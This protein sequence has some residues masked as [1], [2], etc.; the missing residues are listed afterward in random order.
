MNNFGFGGS[1]AHIIMDNASGYVSSRRLSE[2]YKKPTERSDSTHSMTN[3]FADPEGKDESCV[4]LLSSF[5]E[6]SGKQQAKNLA[7]YLLKHRDGY[8]DDLIRDLA[9]TLS[10]RRSN[11]PWKA[12]F[13]AHSLPQL[14]K[15]LSSEEVKFSRIHQPKNIGFVFTGQGAQWHAM[16]RELITQY[17]VF[18]RSLDLADQ[19]IAAMGASW[20]LYGKFILITLVKDL[21]RHH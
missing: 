2:K 10:E 15:A 14:A 8:S 5:D 9:Y 1:N 17:P 4:F 11:L 21:G 6:H 13:A 12:A 7:Q 16:G 20:S 18:R 3:G 19:Y